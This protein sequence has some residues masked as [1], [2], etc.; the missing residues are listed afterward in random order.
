MRKPRQ[1]TGNYTQ[2]IYDPTTGKPLFEVY[3][4]WELIDTKESDLEA[5]EALLLAVSD[6]GRLVDRTE[7]DTAL[8][9]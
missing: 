5:V 3:H 8:T 2:P 9:V 7:L 1:G 6:E 4:H